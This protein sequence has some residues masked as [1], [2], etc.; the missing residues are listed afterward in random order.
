MSPRVSL[1]MKRSKPPAGIALELYQL[2][3]FNQ[4]VNRHRIA[5]SICGQSVS[6]HRNAEPGAKMRRA[7]D[8][9]RVE[10]SDNHFSH[11]PPFSNQ[12]IDKRVELLLLFFVRGSRINDDKLVTADDVAVG[13]CSR[14]QGRRSHR[15][16][17]N[18]RAKLD[19]PNRC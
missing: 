7:A 2:I 4:P 9:I 10:M 11:S 5:D 17:T 3:I 8:M 14:R 1:C 12:P 13:V 6:G 16:K 18:A 15:E 19:A